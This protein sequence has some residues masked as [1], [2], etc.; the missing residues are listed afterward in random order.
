MKHSRKLLLV[1]LLALSVFVNSV[2]CEA[3]APAQAAEA[4]AAQERWVAVVTSAQGGVYVQHP[5]QTQWEPLKVNDKCY[6]GDSIRVEENSRAA[7]L[8]KNDSTLRIDQN[9]SLTFQPMEEQTVVMRLFNGAASFFSRFPRSLKIFTPH[10]NGTVKGTEFV[11]RVDGDQ[12]QLTLF[13]GQVLAE[14]GKGELLLAGGQSV[15]AKKD[16]APVLVTVVR[17]RDAVQWALYYP[18]IQDFGPGD[19][20]GEADWQVK[21]RASV[22][23]WRFPSQRSMVAATHPP[24]SRPWTCP[25]TPGWCTCPSPSPP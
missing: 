15:V 5:G 4:Q 12:T 18:A 22:E 25:F 8:F 1:L 16:Q 19:F 10:M 20:P 3:Q 14:N 21:S 13:E 24:R 7:L 9:T 23:A 17:P 6:P 2:T 11:I